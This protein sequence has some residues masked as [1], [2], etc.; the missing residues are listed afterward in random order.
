MDYKK[1]FETYFK[2]LVFFAEKYLESREESE[3]VVQDTFY[4]L[5]EKRDDFDHEVAVKNFLYLTT[6]NKALNFLRHQKVHEKFSREMMTTLEMESYYAQHMVEEET[7]HLIFQV[8]EN[9][10]DLYRR[11]SLL[12]MDGK[13]NPEIATALEMSVGMVK[14]HKKHLYKLLR[15]KLSDHYYIL[16]FMHSYLS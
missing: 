14:Y 8:V 2:T 10:P 6:R 5:W 13:D 4:A 12:I 15:E 9:L 3:S 11:I 16:F 1:V 7:F